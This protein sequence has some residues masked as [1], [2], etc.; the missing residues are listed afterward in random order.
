MNEVRGAVLTASRTLD[1]SRL[2]IESEPATGAWLEVEACGVCGSDWSWYSQRAIPAPFVPGHEIIGRIVRS[3]GSSELPFPIGARVALEEALPCHSCAV[4]R[5]GRHRLCPNSTRYGGT[6]LSVEPGLWGG[7][8]E[9][10][11]LAPGTNMHAVPDQLD[12]ERATLFVPISN[13]LSWVR[14]AAGLIPGES[15]VVLG[16]GQHGLASVAAARR[17][18][19]GPILAVGRSGDEAR[20]RAAQALGADACIDSDQSSWQSQCTD[21]TDGRGA[22]IVLDTTPGATHTVADAVS[23]AAIGGRIVIAGLKSGR[24]SLVPT[25]VVARRELTIR[26]VAARESWAIDSALSWLAEDGDRFD[27]FSSVTVGL[28]R[29]EDAL[30][31]LGGERPGE[32]PVH[33]VVRPNAA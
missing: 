4:C 13:G 22:D 23:A 29:V 16:V 1:V 10:V 30:L 18:G 5:S 21:M 6:P 31:A 20:L 11:Y 9:L 3:L 15:V 7:F 24:S 28:G 2:S 8:A 32:R 19:A 17:S 12:A 27:A 26:G 25:D 14:S 33:A